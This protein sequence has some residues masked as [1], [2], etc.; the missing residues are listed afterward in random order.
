MSTSVFLARLIGPVMLVIG[1]AVLANQRAFRELAEEF[2]ASRALI[3]LSGLLIMPV[4][5]AIVLV[6]N[7]WAADGRVMITLFGWV[8]LIGGAARLFAPAYVM[9]T[10]RAMLKRPHFVTIAAAFWIVAGLLFCLFG[11][12]H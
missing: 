9:Q 2:L 10:G 3:F 7:I 8:N 5:L 11:I 4:G 6:H 12:L 1:L